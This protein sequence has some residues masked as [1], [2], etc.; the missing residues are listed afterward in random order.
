V[1]G[2]SIAQQQTAHR[3][4]ARTPTASRAAAPA[5]LGNSDVV[6][7]VKAGFSEDLIVVRIK[8]APAKDFDLS[9]K[10]MLDLK[11]AG[12]SERLI[13]VMFGGPDPG[14][15]RAEPKTAPPGSSPAPAANDGS[16]GVVER[17]DAGIYLKATD[18][19][20]PL[21]P[22]VFSGGKTG[23]VLT[24]GLTMGIKK[25]KWKAVVRSPHAGQRVRTTR[26][27][28]YFY[29]ENKNSGLGSSAAMFGAS[30]P[31]EFVLAR[32]TQDDD[33]RQLIVGEFGAF[34]ASSGTRSQDTVPLTITRLQPGIYKV[35]PVDA[36]PVGEYCF[37]YAAGASTFVASGTGKLFDFGVESD[38]R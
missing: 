20:V 37:F 17:L 7:L 23:G 14:V 27:D 33:E 18:K 1:A 13:A 5:A 2:V 3:T 34:G 35:T 22:T 24:S 28:F 21:E 38:A 4:P 30:S 8:Q 11:T 10:G 12:V 31:N 6:A 15:S 26:P 9:T 25:A 16:A 36:L 32:M 29:F 19:Y